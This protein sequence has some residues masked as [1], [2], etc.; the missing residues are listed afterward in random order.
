MVQLFLPMPCY[1]GPCFFLPLV[2]AASRRLRGSVCWRSSSS[3]VCRGDR[4][5]WQWWEHGLE[6][7]SIVG[8]R[9]HRL[10]RKPGTVTLRHPLR[11]PWMARTPSQWS[12]FGGGG[13]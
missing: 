2:P 4:A 11:P 3:R 12:W 9:E 8:S 1:R 5:E 10:E 7:Q 6:W 13:N